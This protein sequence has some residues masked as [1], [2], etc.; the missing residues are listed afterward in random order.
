MIQKDELIGRLLAF[1]ET[2]SLIL[3]EGDYYMIIVGGGALI[4]LDSIHRMTHD[5][6]SISR[7]PKQLEGLLEQYDINTRVLAYE[8]NFPYNYKDRIVPVDIKTKIIKFYNSSLED[9]VVSKLYSS[10]DSDFSDIT[11]PLLLE[12]LDW[13]ILDRLV[14]EPEEAYYSTLNQRSYNE[15]VVNYKE[16]R[17]EYKR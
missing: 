11:N 5:I 13:E 6:D 10:R 17:K 1:D 14:N 8:C 15:L 16:Y 4:L 2:A 12:K 7:L 9:I 3:P